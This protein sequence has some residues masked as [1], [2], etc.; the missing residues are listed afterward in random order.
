MNPN[1]P[2]FVYGTS[3][4]DLRKVVYLSAQKDV[5]QSIVSSE[6]EETYYLKTTSHY[7]RVFVDGDQ[8]P[9]TFSLDTAESFISH[10]FAFNGMNVPDQFKGLFESVKEKIP[11][12]DM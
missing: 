10:Y 11:Y 6:N 7:I 1:N 9:F 8:D 5:V 2:I 4:L 3:A 12:C